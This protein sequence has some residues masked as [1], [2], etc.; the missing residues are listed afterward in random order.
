MGRLS[1]TPPTQQ[2]SQNTTL[3]IPE[4]N[5]NSNG[6]PQNSSPAPLIQAEIPTE[7]LIVLPV[8]NASPQIDAPAASP[9]T[10]NNPAG[11]VSDPSP[12][13]PGI[14]STTINILESIEFYL[15]QSFSNLF[16]KLVDNFENN[17]EPSNVNSNN[18]RE[19]VTTKI[20]EAN[21][22]RNTARPPR[23]NPEDSDQDL[24]IEN[25]SSRRSQSGSSPIDISIEINTNPDDP[26][27]PI[28]IEILVTK[29]VGVSVN[30]NGSPGR[31]PPNSDGPP[32]QNPAGP[33][34][35]RPGNPNPQAEEVNPDQIPRNNI[36][37]ERMSMFTPRAHKNKFKRDL[38]KLPN[39][40]DCFNFGTPRSR[41][42]T[43]TPSP[44]STDSDDLQTSQRLR[45]RRRTPTTR[46]R[47]G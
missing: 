45:N 8:V 43:T 4:A 39:H 13:Q 20:D 47:S 41:A 33:P 17:N 10:N 12:I 42:Q 28:V 30:Q 7:I 16:K 18:N 5:A 38:N 11:S 23:E 32:G 44:S 25:I 3:V 35:L 2:T 46:R 26:P 27:E 29:G 34:G 24:S 15:K 19:D 36:P 6:P 9:N 31:G 40:A 14:E 37:E 21:P 22:G 1:N